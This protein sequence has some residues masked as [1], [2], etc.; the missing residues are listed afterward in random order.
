MRAVIKLEPT[1]YSTVAVARI[2]SSPGQM[3]SRQ[4]HGVYS[5]HLCTVIMLMPFFSYAIHPIHH[6][7][8]DSIERMV[9]I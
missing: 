8:R 1:A 6:E 7:S 9:N 3:K 5:N 2:I 4:G